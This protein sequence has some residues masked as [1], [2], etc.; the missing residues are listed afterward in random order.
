[1]L[2]FNLHKVDVWHAWGVLNPCRWYPLW[3]LKAWMSIRYVGASP[4][5]DGTPLSY[6]EP[7]N[8]LLDCIVI[9]NWQGYGEGD[10]W[11]S[12][13]Q[14]TRHE[15]FA[16][17][18]FEFFFVFNSTESY[19]PVAANKLKGLWSEHSQTLQNQNNIKCVTAPRSGAESASESVHLNITHICR[20]T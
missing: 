4:C 17:L 16:I 6:A 20:L 14:N 11:H 18:F 2:S 15:K 19:W 3:W 12:S 10:R 5:T 1:M 9:I 8:Y 13:Q 7:P